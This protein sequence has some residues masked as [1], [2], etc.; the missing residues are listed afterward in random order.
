MLP[1]RGFKHW[2]IFRMCPGFTVVLSGLVCP[3]ILMC[4]HTERN[5]FSNFH[6]STAVTILRMRTL[7]AICGYVH[8][9]VRVDGGSSDSNF[10]RRAWSCHSW[11]LSKT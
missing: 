3:P 5:Q 8:L 7:C 2:Q 6:S 9:S 1:K 4:V 10:S 11:C